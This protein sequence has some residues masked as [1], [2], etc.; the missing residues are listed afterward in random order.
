[1]LD[2][3]CWAQEREV[4]T[5]SFR[6]APHG[7]RLGRESLLGSRAGLCCSH[8]DIC[9]VTES[10]AVPWT[11]RPFHRLYLFLSQETGV[12]P[13]QG[14]LSGRSCTPGLEELA[15]GEGSGGCAGG[16]MSH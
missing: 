3:T 4:C 9:F 14:V 1:M 15:S 5:F 16:G 7:P 12:V 2:V 10:A 13:G 8:M 11:A 6:P